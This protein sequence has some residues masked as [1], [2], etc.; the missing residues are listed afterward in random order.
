MIHSE[1]MNKFW[2]GVSLT[3]T[4]VIHQNYSK[5][6]NVR[7]SGSQTVAGTT[8]KGYRA[9]LLR[10]DRFFSRSSKSKTF[11][12]ASIA[13]SIQLRILGFPTLLIWSIGKRWSNGTSSSRIG[14][15]RPFSNKI[16]VQSQLTNWT[17][18]FMHWTFWKW[19]MS[20]KCL[21]DFELVHRKRATLLHLLAHATLNWNRNI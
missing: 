5:V 9:V 18:N 6:Q 12:L 13:L 16:S 14:A 1:N 4:A 21:G 15:K 8:T 20:P 7:H 17:D 10:F 2:T 11:N 3:A 19:V